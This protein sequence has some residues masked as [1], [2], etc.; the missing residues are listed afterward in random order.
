MR[1]S[2][3]D[4]VGFVHV[5]DL[6]GPAART[7]GCRVGDLAREVAQ[8]PGT[9]RV[10]P[11]LSELRRAGMHLAIVV[12]EYGGTAGIVTLEDLVE[13]LIGDIRDEYDVDEQASRR[14][15]GGDLEVDGLLNLDDFEDETGFELPEGPYE[16][17]AGY[18]M[19]S[20]GHIPAVGEAV[21]VAGHRI[22]V[23]EKD[24]R[25]AR[26]R[27][28]G[29]VPTVAPDEPPGLAGAAEAGHNE[30]DRHARRA[31]CV[32]RHAADRR[33]APP[34]QLPR[35]AAQWVA[36][37]ETHDAFFCVV[38]LHA[39]TVG[40]RPRRAAGA[41]ADHRR[42]VP[43]RRHRRRRAARCSC[44]ATCPSTPS[45]PGCSAASP[46]SARPAG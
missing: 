18:V 36:L 9:K 11:A 2:A 43:R 45:W 42:A 17:V 5:R 16:T 24:G 41:H 20:L 6:F 37:Q 14:L 10:L 32:L 23:T 4:V 34:G 39:I 40:A 46:A 28:A 27:L 3:D 33:L 21:E 30:N 7:T 38:D 22:T 44:R 19:S 1:G 35:R 26:V 29:P 8:L 25:R 12:D 31:P 13:E 15:R